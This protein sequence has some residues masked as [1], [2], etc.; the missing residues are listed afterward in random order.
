[1]PS[2]RPAS[3]YGGYLLPHLPQIVSWRRAGVS[4]MDIGRLLYGLGLRPRTFYVACGESDL[5][6]LAYERECRIW[7]LM[8]LARY[9]YSNE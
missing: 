7:T 6:G 4:W 8:V 1:M 9:A 3:G 2:G 5:D